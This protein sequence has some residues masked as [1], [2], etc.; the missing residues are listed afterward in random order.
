MTPWLNVPIERPDA[1][2]RLLCIP[3]AG[4]G[5]SAYRGWARF[6]P[7]EVE[8]CAV[9]P[10]GRENRFTEPPL[11]TI[12]EIADGIADALA[13]E[14]DDRPLIVFGHSMGA[15]VAFELARVLRA[16]GAAMPLLL[17]LS[18][19]VAPHL[20]PHRPPIY[21]LPE[22]EFL[23]RIRIMEGTP[24]AVFEQ[25]ELLDFYLPVLR[26]D[27]TACDTYVCAPEPPLAMPF[28]VL[29]GDADA[30][31]PVEDVA[32]WSGHTTAEYAL[33]VIPGGHFFPQ[34]ARDAVLREI[35]SAIASIDFKAR[36]GDGARPK[37]QEEIVHGRS[38]C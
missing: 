5:A 7:P 23:A 16:R 29:A 3:Y 19:H 9:Q 8:L 37:T 17:I 14:A 21:D 1:S 25:R 24:A 4:G 36:P 28:L 22:R 11:R 26:A 35:A 15:L 10:P 20:A 38:N 32:A 6:V 27:F 2:A 30:T 34:T 12:R 31:M 13:C 33:R 18:G